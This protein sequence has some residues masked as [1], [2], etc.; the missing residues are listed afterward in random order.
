MG[1]TLITGPAVEPLSLAEAKAHL[2]VTVPDHDAIIAG[3]I[4]AARRYAEG[5]MRGALITQTWDYTVDNSWP[6]QR[7]EYGHCFAA[8]V[9]RIEL[10]LGPVQSVTS[11]S[12]LDENGATQ[13]LSGSLYTL[14]KDRPVAFIAKAYNADWPA[15]RNVPAAITIRFVC[16]YL[17]EAVPDDLRAALLMHVELL[18]DRNTNQRELLEGS[19]DNLLDPHRILDV[20]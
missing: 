10:P 19:R 11:V 20:A 12:Y 8:Y 18:F 14:H 13:T 2:R 17:P 9:S 7:V 6:Y 3:H 16:G 5:Y 15:V 4:L 1:L